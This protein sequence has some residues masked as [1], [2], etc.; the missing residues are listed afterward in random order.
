MSSVANNVTQ[1][2]YP[3]GVE[4]N[5]GNVLTPRQVKDQPKVR[6]DAKPDTFYTLC[7]TGI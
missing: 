7:M 2:V 6:W 5:L 3:S 4:V 1:V